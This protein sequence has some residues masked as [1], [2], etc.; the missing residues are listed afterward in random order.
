MCAA[1]FPSLGAAGAWRRRSPGAA[2]PQEDSGGRWELGT[3]HSPQP[4]QLPHL[5]SAIFRYQ[6]EL[7]REKGKFSARGIVLAA[8]PSG[9]RRPPGARPWPQMRVYLSLL[10][11]FC[12]LP[13][14]MASIGRTRAQ[15]PLATSSFSGWFPL[16]S[17]SARQGLFLLQEGS[18]RRPVI[19]SVSM[20]PQLGGSQVLG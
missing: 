5:C 2:H 15:F 4:K 3:A 19:V 14:S 20:A 1:P 9:W 12:C 6:P 16:W 10:A 13:W 17:S 7:G 11:T 18:A 8:T